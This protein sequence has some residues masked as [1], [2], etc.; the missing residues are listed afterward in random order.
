MSYDRQHQ[1]VTRTIVGAIAGV[2]L[3]AC[4]GSRQVPEADHPSTPLTG[5]EWSLVSL[6]GKPADAGNGGKPAT[7]T[8]TTA[9]NRVSGF[10]GCNRLAGSYEV[11]ADSL[12]LGPLILTRMAC[13]SGM[14]LE[15]QFTGALG[16]TRRYRI[17]DHR[18]DLLSDSGVVASLESR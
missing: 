6:N 11:A 4:G 2:G 17:D 7:L 12:T 14:E 10:A 9:D 8:L 5:T 15:Q 13:P 3:L 1:A 18:L 16:A